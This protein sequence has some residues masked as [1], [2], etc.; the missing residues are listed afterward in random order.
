[1]IKTLKLAFLFSLL[2]MIFLP[3]TSY[4]AD[5][6][7]LTWEKGRVQEIILS[8]ENV[9]SDFS[10]QMVGSDGSRVDFIPSEKNADGFVVFTAQIPSSLSVGV[11]TIESVESSGIKTI[12]AGV[13]LIT[14]VT[15]DIKA[16]RQDLTLVVGLFTFITVT[17]SSL[18]SRKYSTLSVSRSEILTNFGEKNLIG[19]VLSKIVNLRAELTQGVSPSLFRHLLG[20]ESQ[21]LSRLSKPLYFFLPVLALAFGLFA[22]INAQANGGLEK[23][24][25]LFFFIIT[26][27][28]L[29]DSFSGIFALFAFWAVQFFYGDVASINQILIMVAA[30]IAWIGPSLAAR[31]YQD[32]IKKDFTES[33]QEGPVAIGMAVISSATAATAL[34]FG[35]YKLLIS[36]LGEVSDDWQM[37]PIYLLFIFLIALGKAI[38]IEKFASPK[39]EVTTE[40]FEIVRVVSP[41]VALSALLIVYGFAYIWTES[42]LRSLI[43]AL[44]FAAPYFLLFI[45]FE[46]IGS[47]IFAKLKRNFILESVFAVAASYLIYLQV[48]RLPELTDQR[49]E[50]YL[51]AA[52]IP[53]LIHGIYSSICDSAQREG[54][55]NP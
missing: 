3:S 4:A 51:I 18:R 16:E 23:S 37:K 14:E 28:G 21:L 34:F 54:R 10:I 20:Q 41:Q 52:A 15:Y 53:G 45:R 48:Q 22:A 25:L 49:A 33:T 9:N 38:F 5:I 19:R 46:P 7:F 50:I 17:L 8:D 31:I 29:I 2:A 12:L 32:A 42:A 6:P 26:A 24:Q 1:M 55:I 27:I 36:L 11:Y 47:Q 39:N 44:L 35:G 13:N 30:A 40:N 43:A